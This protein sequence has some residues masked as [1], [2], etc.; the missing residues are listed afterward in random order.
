M[1][2]L[3]LGYWKIRGLAASI[4]YQLEYSGV[5]YDMKEYEQG[6]GPE[7]SRQ[8]WLDEKYKFELDFPNL[9]YVIDGDFYLTET[10]A[11]HKYLADKYDQELL[12][13]NAEQQGIVNM[14]SGIILDIKK[15]VTGPCYSGDKDAAIKCIQNKMP[16]VI[17]FLKQ[18]QRQFLAGDNVTWID[19]YFYETLQLM[20]FINP[21]V[22]E[23]Y[24]KLKAYCR[25]MAKLPHLKDY[26]EDLTS[27]DNNR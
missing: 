9:P 23:E 5:D 3:T 27:L 16:A 6:V 26:L 24:G 18:D 12:G 21:H 20:A 14:L 11:I 22:Y 19:F 1:P 17:A 25:N 2:K 13:V 15:G 10:F 7:F 4:R 8:D